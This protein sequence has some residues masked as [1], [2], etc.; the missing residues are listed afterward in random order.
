MLGGMSRGGL[1]A[2]HAAACSERGV[3]LKLHGVGGEKAGGERQKDRR[4][5]QKVSSVVA[6]ALRG[7]TRSEAPMIAHACCPLAV[8]AGTGT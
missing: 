7:F 5:C 2:A 6:Q 3:L 4:T 1:C 8:A